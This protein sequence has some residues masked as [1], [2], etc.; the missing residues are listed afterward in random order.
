MVVNGPPCQG[1]RCRPPAVLASGRFTTR[2]L[3]GHFL[4]GPL[5]GAAL[6]ASEGAGDAAV[7]PPTL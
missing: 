6:G 2:L 1:N 3:A 7:R 4:R 5:E